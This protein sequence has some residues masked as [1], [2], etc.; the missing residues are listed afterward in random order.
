MGY[1]Q[2][3]VKLPLWMR[4]S[5]MKEAIERGERM[6]N[7]L[8][9]M[10]EKVIDGVPHWWMRKNGQNGEWDSPDRWTTDPNKG[11]KYDT[12]LEAE[13]VIGR[14]MVGCIATEHIFM[15]R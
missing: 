7:K 13:Y 15:D 12:K 6:E 1:A 4:H 10:I 9:W 5:I 2:L 14:D 8:F 11:R 3:I